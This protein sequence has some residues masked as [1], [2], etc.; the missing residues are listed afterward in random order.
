[1]S[2]DCIQQYMGFNHPSFKQ[3][4]IAKDTFV[5]L[6]MKGYQKLYGQARKKNK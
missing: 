6:T 1:M 4:L 2:V 5:V 3:N